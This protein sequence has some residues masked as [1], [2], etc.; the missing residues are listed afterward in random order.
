MNDNGIFITFSYNEREIDGIEEFKQELDVSYPNLGIAKWIPSCSEGGEFWISIFFD[1]SFWELVK[2]FAQDAIKAAILLGGK[3]FVLDPLRTAMTNLRKRNENGW[4]LKVQKASFKFN[5][6]EVIIGGLKEE[7][8]AH[9]D[10]VFQ[11]I[12]ERR[13][14]LE[15]QGNGFGIK[16]IEMPAEFL[17]G[18][19][20]WDLAYWRDDT[21]TLEES[22]WIITYKD[23]AKILYD[24]TTGKFHNY[25]DYR[26]EDFDI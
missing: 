11:I 10:K 2:S 26:P 19:K 20:N 6:L 9:L 22:F 18:P 24:S 7:E 21:P 23:N 5:N 12:R 1:G 15:L 25:N 16:R 13:E 14:K 3:K 8:F 17:W 4:P